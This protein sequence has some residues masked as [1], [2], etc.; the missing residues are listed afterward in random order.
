MAGSK[1][2]TPPVPPEKVEEVDE[3]SDESFPASDPPSWTLGRRTEPV[4]EADR[5]RDADG[6][7]RGRISR[8]QSPAQPGP[9]KGPDRSTH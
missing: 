7:R 1:P 2:K 8:R 9:A 4:R 5:A 3:S 6:A